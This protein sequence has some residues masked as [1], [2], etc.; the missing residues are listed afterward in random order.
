MFNYTKIVFIVFALVVFSARTCVQDTSTSSLEEEKITT[1]IETKAD[2]ANTEA[3]TPIKSSFEECSKITRGVLITHCGS[4]HQSSLNSHKA[5]A[6]KFFDLDMGTH[7]HTSLS[8]ENL[9]GIAR[10]TQN[11]STITKHQKEAIA[12]F[13]KLKDLQLQK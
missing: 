1:T 12:T 5:G 13:L 3:F 2:K 11:K 4:C 6:I 8:Q 10:R 9:P 7:W